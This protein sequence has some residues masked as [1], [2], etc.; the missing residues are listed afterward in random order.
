MRNTIT[1][2]F[3]LNKAGK[4]MPTIH[5]FSTLYAAV[6]WDKKQ[7]FQDNDFYD[8]RHATAA[9][10]YCDY[11]FTEKRLAHLLMQNLLGLDKFYQCTVHSKEKEAI[12]CLH[13]LETSP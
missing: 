2:I 6:R 4:T 12:S 10:P 1:N 7:K 3:R 11:F 5:I 8:F 13:K 9:L